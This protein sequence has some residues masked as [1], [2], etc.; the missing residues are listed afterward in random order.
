MEDFNSW[1]YSLKAKDL[2]CEEENQVWASYQ[3]NW[4]ELPSKCCIRNDFALIEKYLLKFCKLEIQK[5]SKISFMTCLEFTSDKMCLL[6]FQ[7]KY[8]DEDL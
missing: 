7:N 3:Y 6:F 4:N 8:L 1:K 5:S 2:L